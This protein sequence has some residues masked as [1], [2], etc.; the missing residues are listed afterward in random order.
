[1]K[2]LKEKELY[3]IIKCES[4]EKINIKATTDMTFKKLESLLKLHKGT[5]QIKYM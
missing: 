3:F 1:M 4:G 5:C 2:K